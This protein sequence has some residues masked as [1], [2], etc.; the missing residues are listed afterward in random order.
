MKFKAPS[1][2]D[3][4]NSRPRK[5]I[6]ICER[7]DEESNNLG[8]NPTV[9]RVLESVCGSSGVHEAGR[10][11][12]FRDE[13]RYVGT[14]GDPAVRFIYTQDQATRLLEIINAAYPRDDGHQSM[15]HHSF[16]GGPYHFHIQISEKDA[17]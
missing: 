4:F 11:V 10:A 2:T 13:L 6:Q 8:I 7:F 5:L 17:V 9:T 16:D 15:I 1:L 12:D 3:E 14:T